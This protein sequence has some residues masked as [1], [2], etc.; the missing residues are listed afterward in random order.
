MTAAEENLFRRLLSQCDARN[1]FT[2][3]IPSE[4]VRAFEA[5]AFELNYIQQASAQGA[6]MLTDAGVAARRTLIMQDEQRAR[7]EALQAQV[8]SFRQQLIQ[9]QRQAAEAAEQH[10][11]LDEA[12]RAQ[13]KSFRQ[14]LLQVQQQAV[15]ALERTRNEF[16]DYKAQQAEQHA[17]DEDQRILDRK[18]ST[19]NQLICSALSVCLTLFLEHLPDVI[20]FVD[21]LLKSAFAFFHD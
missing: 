17:R 4:D 9:V 3:S 19:R 21:V 20:G 18:Q 12:L 6:Y 1:R 14:Q 5:L 10:L 16:S 7:E 2:P 8:E 11:S 13:E 15:E